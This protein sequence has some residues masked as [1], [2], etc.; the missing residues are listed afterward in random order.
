MKSKKSEK[1]KCNSFTCIRILVLVRF[2][3]V[4][5]GFFCIFA[6]IL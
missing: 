1:E 3:L 4:G 5:F 2:N 6:F